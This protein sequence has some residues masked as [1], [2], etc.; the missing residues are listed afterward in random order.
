MGWLD[1]DKERA[2]AWLVAALFVY[3]M[4]INRESSG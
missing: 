3:Q 1:K 2:A 4:Y